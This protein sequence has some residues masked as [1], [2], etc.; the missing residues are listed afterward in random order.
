MWGRCSQDGS[1]VTRH[2]SIAIPFANVV[3]SLGPVTVR[4][5]RQGRGWDADENLSGLSVSGV[6]QVIVLICESQL[7]F[8]KL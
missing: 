4:T 6:T 1:L 3:F 2:I 5:W 7:S 8:L